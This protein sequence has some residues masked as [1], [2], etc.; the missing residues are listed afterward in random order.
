MRSASGGIWIIATIL[1]SVYTTSHEDSRLVSCDCYRYLADTISL[2]GRLS[3]RVYPGPPEYES[4]ARGD[5]PDTIAVLLVDHPLC[6]ESS[7]DWQSRANVKEVQLI[8][9]PNQYHWLLRLR[10][11]KVTVRGYLRG[12]DFG[13]HHLDVLFQTRLPEFPSRIDGE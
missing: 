3:W 11:S 13:W 6:V 2:V 10:G 8:L 5:H 9:P 4:I 12:A 1:G 7:K